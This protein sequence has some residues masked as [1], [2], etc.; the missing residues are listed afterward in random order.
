[1]RNF[2]KRGMES[3]W[4]GCDGLERETKLRTRASIHARISGPKIHRNK[5]IEV[6]N[7]PLDGAKHGG[8]SAGSACSSLAAAV[9]VGPQDGDGDE[10]GKPEDHGEELGSQ[11]A[12]LVSGNRVVQRSEDEV[13][14]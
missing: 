3:P 13:G 6:S 2:A 7:L 10:A 12:K 9:D 4:K 1:M 5:N 14:H 8:R 11:N